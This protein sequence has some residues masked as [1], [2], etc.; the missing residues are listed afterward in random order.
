MEKNETNQTMLY[1]RKTSDLYG[2][3]ALVVAML[4][5]TMKD[6]TV[7]NSEIEISPYDSTKVREQKK[8]KKFCKRDAYRF[9]MSEWFEDW[10]W[11]IGIDPDLIRRYAMDRYNESKKK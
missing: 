10:C 5:L 8:E 3:K 7:P 6:L 2:Y 11:F 1:P 4:E 9:V